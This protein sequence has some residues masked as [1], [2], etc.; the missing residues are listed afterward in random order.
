MEIERGQTSSDGSARL[1]STGG[2]QHT[3]NTGEE[4]TEHPAQPLRFH[5]T[6]RTIVITQRANDGERNKR[7]LKL[8][9]CAMLQELALG[10]AIDLAVQWGMWG[11]S[12]LLKTEKFYDLTGSGTFVLLANLSL[13]WG[14]TK[15]LRQKIQTGLVTVWG[16]RLGGF[17]FLRILKE[18]QDKRF[19]HVRESPGTFFVYWTVQGIWIFVTLLP[20][21]ILN[22]EKH[23]RPLGLRDYLGWTIWAVGFVTQAIAD[24]Q[25]WNFR[26]DPDNTV[27]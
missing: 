15:Y 6:K 23:D 26:A 25:K 2:Q 5:P 7:D 9:R 13:R 18:G 17:L 27:S 19:N 22:L 8:S 3:R 21:L 11:I 24:Q 16:L 14:N 1:S 20:T 4:E 12:A 10:A